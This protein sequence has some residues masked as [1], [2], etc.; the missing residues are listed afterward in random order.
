MDGG[1]LQPATRMDVSVAAIS[2]GLIFAL[3]RMAEPYCLAMVLCDYVHRDPATQKCSVLGTFSVFGSSSYPSVARFLV[4]FAI[5]DGMGDVELTL[6]LVD[7]SVGLTEQTEPI[8]EVKVPML[9][10]SP[11]LVVEGQLEVVTVLPRAGVYHCELLADASPLMS[12]RLI[13]IE[14]SQ[15]AAE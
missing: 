7:S 12:R 5:T 4:Y 10:D 14:A 8:F 6:K 13:A 2:L 9:L 3:W 11:L 1:R 15:N